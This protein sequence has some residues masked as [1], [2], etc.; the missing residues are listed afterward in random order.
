MGGCKGAARGVDLGAWFLFETE[1]GER[2]DV[3]NF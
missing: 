2:I 1:S 3:S